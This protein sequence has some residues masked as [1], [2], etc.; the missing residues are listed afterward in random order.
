MNAVPK[1]P[2]DLLPWIY[3]GLFFIVVP[4]VALW[5]ATKPAVQTNLP[6]AVREL[7]PYHLITAS[8]VI[9]RSVSPSDIV[10]NT[11]RNSQDIV[12]RYTREVIA[13][14][15]PIRGNQI[16]A[17]ADARLISNTLAVAIPTTS[18]TILGGKLRAGDVV[19]LATVPISDTST[20]PTILFDAVLVLEMQAND[21][22]AVVVLAIP[23][24][25]WLEFL[26]KTHDAQV[27]LARRIE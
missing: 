4:I 24:N 13:D 14:G 26:A 17:V 18:A 1:P 21:K 19:S 9:T 5:M 10:S 23:A 25:R 8:D 2:R 6:V 15:K 12:G 27:V 7:P 20:A 22:D 16:A 11:V 3:W